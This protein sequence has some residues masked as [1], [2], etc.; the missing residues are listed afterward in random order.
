MMEK[1]V[2]EGYKKY[3][4]WAEQEKQK[5]EIEKTQKQAPQVVDIRYLNASIWELSGFMFRLF[6]ASIPAVIGAVVFF[7]ILFGVFAGM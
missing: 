5:T 2:E 4:D 7:K 1:S 6:V 3:E